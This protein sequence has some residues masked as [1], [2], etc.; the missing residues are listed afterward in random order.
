MKIGI[1]GG[2]FDP[3]HLGHTV[4]V[5]V[6]SAQFGLDIVWFLPSFLPPHKRRPDLT[7]SYHRAAMVAIALQP[8]PR[9]LLSPEELAT[10]M[11]RY[12]VDTL[13][14]WKGRLKPEDRLFFIMGSDSFMEIET[15]HDHGRLLQQCEFIIIDRGIDQE[16]LKSKLDQIEKA[17]QLRLTE[18]I[19]FAPTPYLPISSTEIRKSL[20]DGLSVSASLSPGVEEYI[21]KQS[22]Y[23]R[24]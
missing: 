2:T 23:Q 6:V 17:L 21:K 18:I 16:A 11:V 20:H 24:R 13:A 14:A 3:P 8:Y 10:G 12:T 7:D 4:P 22:L 19:H 5:E 15:W 9:F 1:M